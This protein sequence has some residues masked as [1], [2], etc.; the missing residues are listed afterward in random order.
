MVVVT[1]SHTKSVGRSRAC[2]QATSPITS[3]DTWLTVM[4]R[5]SPARLGQFHADGSGIGLR[6]ESMEISSGVIN[7][8]RSF[9]LVSPFLSLTTEQTGVVHT[10]AVTLLYC[11]DRL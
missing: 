3:T 9:H 5:P 10:D 1:I 11:R 8:F 2:L 7:L 4:G 6:I